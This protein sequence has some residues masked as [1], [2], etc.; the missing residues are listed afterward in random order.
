ML[1]R[2]GYDTQVSSPH[3][4]MLDRSEANGQSQGDLAPRAVPLPGM[5]PFL[6]APRLAE[7]LG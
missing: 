2:P 5:S 3:M 4:N 7:N 1:H 6:Y